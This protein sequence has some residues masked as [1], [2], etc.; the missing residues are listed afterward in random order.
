MNIK[1]KIF[2]LILAFFPLM[3]FSATQEENLKAKMVTDLDI[4]KSFFEAKY[5]PAL[6]KKSYAGW[7]LNEQ[8]NLSKKKVQQKKN[9]SVKDYNKI[10]RDFFNSTKDYHV[11]VQFYSTEVSILPF[12]VQGVKGKYFITWV[13]PI[14]N[15]DTSG[16]T[17]QL[18]FK[19][20]DELVLF[21]GKATDRAVKEVKARELGNPDSQ[22][23]QM[24]AEALLTFR[25]GLAGHE[26][27]KGPIKITIKHSDTGRLDT[28]QL[29]W[30]HIPEKIQNCFKSL[31]AATPREA[32]NEKGSLGAHPY[33]HKKMSTP[34]HDQFKEGYNA[35]LSH[36][37]LNK[38]KAHS[39]E[40]EDDDDDGFSILGSRRG[41][42]PQLGPIEWQAPEEC[43]FH[44]YIF[45][46]PTG[47]KIGF[48]RLPSFSGNN[49]LA[50]S[51]EE[52]IGVFEN[53]TDA[54]VI[55]QL[56]NPGGSL[57]YLYSIVGLLAN[58]P[59]LLPM[60]R[61]TITQE[62]VSTALEYLS[63]IE[64]FSLNEL[65]YLFGEK[66]DGYVVDEN[67]IKGLQTHFQ[68]IVDQ[69]GIGKYF[70]D[71]SY[72]YGIQTIQPNKS[73][74]YSKPILFLVNSLDFSC[75]DF[76]P[77]ILQDNKRAT[78]CGTQTAGAGGLVIPGGYFNRFGL[79]SFS[80]TASIAERPNHMPIENLGVTPDIVLEITEND[81]KHGY[82]DYKT[83]IL[84]LVDNLAK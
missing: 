62:D 55:D 21:D 11:N 36:A 82:Q 45:K 2:I 37:G 69:W 32:K 80:I 81:L 51:L 46:S 78:I 30:I 73:T 71:N 3:A 23:D 22:T 24:L 14:D 4:I 59:C 39:E 50:E 41:F 33:F 12:K 84:K 52:V 26:I 79:A 31:A 10:V 53:R 65:L 15:D 43:P 34:L 44:A 40:E 13:L 75:A 35:F 16:I 76:L 57:F 77:A 9:I 56:N 8:I 66:I 70:T 61:L 60:E 67:F 72:H 42:I 68:F 18:P 48:L 29:D 19:T 20:G 49:F 54:M 74:H 25:L 64:F 7:D 27:P 83:S 1:Q 38:Q 28:Y 47:K 5:A 6:W 63:K 58:E 17:Y